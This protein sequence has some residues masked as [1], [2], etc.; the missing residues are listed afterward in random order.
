[1]GDKLFKPPLVEVVFELKWKDDQK[2]DY[3]LLV[4][5]LYSQ[6]KS[7][8]PE[9]ELLKPSEIPSFAMPFKVQHRFREGK[10]DYP[11][12][13]LGP[14]ILS[15]NINGIKYADINGWD[16]FLNKITEFIKKYLVNFL[17]KQFSINKIHF[18]VIS[19]LFFYNHPKHTYIQ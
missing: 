2:E 17:R 3:D 18:T 5:E 16:N 10:N 9:K 14:G 13:Q 6:L 15:F 7:E 12:Y 1:M 11:L 8:F 19:S 4:G